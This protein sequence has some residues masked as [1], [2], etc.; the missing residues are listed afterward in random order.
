MV[1][2]AALFPFD[3]VLE[4]TDGVLDL[5][6]YLVRPALQFQLGITDCRPTTCLTAPLT[7]F[8]DPTIRSLSIILSSPGKAIKRELGVCWCM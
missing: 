8:A 2:A 7:C 5:A 6:L 3:H 4:A 1:Y